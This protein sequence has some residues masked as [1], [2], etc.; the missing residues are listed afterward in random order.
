MTKAE[1][2]ERGEQRLEAL[3]KEHGRL[4][5]LQM[6]MGLTSGMLRLISPYE[7]DAGNMQALCGSMPD[8]AWQ[9]GVLAVVKELASRAKEAADA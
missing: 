6:I 3:R 7:L 4:A 2:R 8:D 1:K 5:E 9:I